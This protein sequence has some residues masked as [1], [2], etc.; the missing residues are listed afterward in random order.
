MTYDVA[1]VGETENTVDR[2]IAH[3]FRRRNVQFST[4]GSWN[5]YIDTRMRGRAGSRNDNF[6]IVITLYYTRRVEG[7][8]ISDLACSPPAPV[9]R[10]KKRMEQRSEVKCACGTNMKEF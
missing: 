5:E 9:A 1:R 6:E 3:D 10:V 7:G 2:S 4:I 8:T